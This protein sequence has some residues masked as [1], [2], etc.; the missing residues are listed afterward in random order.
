MNKINTE[1]LNH[2]KKKQNNNQVGIQRFLKMRRVEIIRGDFP[3]FHQ[4]INPSEY[5]FFRTHSAA[6]KRMWQEQVR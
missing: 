1:S 6:F 5:E 3:L 4:E 2:K